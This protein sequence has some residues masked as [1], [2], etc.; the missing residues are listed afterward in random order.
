MHVNKPTKWRDTERKE[1]LR[2]KLLQG[3][4]KDEEAYEDKEEPGRRLL[5]HKLEG[6]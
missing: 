4:D 6:A 2:R 3:V 5:P 1:R